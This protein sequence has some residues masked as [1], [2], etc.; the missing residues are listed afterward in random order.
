ML[1]RSQ[2]PRVRACQAGKAPCQ[3]PTCSNSCSCS[4]LVSPRRPRQKGRSAASSAPPSTPSCKHSTRAGHVGWGTQKQ[5]AAPTTAGGAGEMGGRPEHPAALPCLAHLNSPQRRQETRRM[6]CLQAPK[7]VAVA[8]VHGPV[9][10]HVARVA[11]PPNVRGGKDAH[12]PPQP[13]LPHQPRQRR[14]QQRAAL[15]AASVA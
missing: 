9:A 5:D 4:C 7:P 12:L 15:A 6:A 14:R 2:K 10:H 13:A 11:V 3:L 1:P 8:W